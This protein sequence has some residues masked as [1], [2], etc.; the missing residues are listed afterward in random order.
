MRDTAW[1]CEKTSTYETVED[2]DALHTCAWCNKR[3]APN[4]EVFSLG[5]KARKGSDLKRYRG[6]SIRLPLKHVDKVVPAMLAAPGSQA[7]KAGNDILFMLCGEQ[8]AK[9]LR[10][11]LLKEKFTIV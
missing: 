6:S 7:K 1:E 11:A 9:Q 3:I 5:A 2:E 8:C 4:S 10:K